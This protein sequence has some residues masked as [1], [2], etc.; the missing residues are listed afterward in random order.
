MLTTSTRFDYNL[1]LL[2][3]GVTDTSDAASAARETVRRF[4][5]LLLDY[6]RGL[7]SEMDTDCSSSPVAAAAATESSRTAGMTVVGLSKVSSLPA[8]EILDGEG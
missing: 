4:E 2:M 8:D 7:L 5:G 3:A 1:I 6:V